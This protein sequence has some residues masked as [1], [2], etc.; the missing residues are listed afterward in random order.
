M[1]PI[2]RQGAGDEKAF[3]PCSF[4]DRCGRLDAHPSTLVVQ[5]SLAICPNILSKSLGKNSNLGNA[6]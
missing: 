5:N 4:N 3:V 2:N 1:E 6:A